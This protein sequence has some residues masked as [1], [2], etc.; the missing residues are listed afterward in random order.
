MGLT[1]QTSFQ[2]SEGFSVTSVYCRII[3]V[4]FR[5]YTQNQS[6]ITFKMEFHLDRNARLLGKAPVRIPNLGDAQTYVG[7]LGDMS[8]LYDV[9]KTSLE[10]SG[11][12]VENVIEESP[13]PLPTEIPPGPPADY[14]VGETPPS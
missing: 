7:V 9:L 11:F 12:V 13:P 6:T 8:Y 2:T 10:A 1:I 5:P 4:I 14:V 3:E